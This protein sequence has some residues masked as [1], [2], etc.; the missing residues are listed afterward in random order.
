MFQNSSADDTVMVAISVFS[1]KDE[2]SEKD[3]TNWSTG[4][5]VCRWLHQES[6]T[7]FQTWKSELKISKP[8]KP[9]SPFFS[10]LQGHKAS[11]FYKS[12]PIN[13]INVTL[14]INICLCLH[15][16]LNAATQITAG[17]LSA[18]HA[19]SRLHFYGTVG[20]CVMYSEWDMQHG[21]LICAKCPQEGRQK[22]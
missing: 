13:N 15:W 4:L 18:H 3:M 21:I 12:A 1:E 7:R 5:I 8:T 11:H 6:C 17:I 10:S 16:S 2:E 20:P 14:F 9:R 19:L 22:P